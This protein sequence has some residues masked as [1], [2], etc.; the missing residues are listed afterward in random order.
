MRPDH[1]ALCSEPLQDDVAFGLGVELALARGAGDLAEAPEWVQVFPAGPAIEARDGRKWTL[2]DPQILVAALE[3]HGADLPLD[4]EHA[5][6]IRAPKGEEAPAQGWVQALQVRAD[7]TTW[8]RVDWNDAGRA[9]VVGRRYRYIS[10]AFRFTPDGQIVHLTSVA[11][12]TQPALR[13]PALARADGGDPSRK[14]TPSMSTL[15]ARLT[16][17]LGLAATATEDD[18]I[19]S[20]T[21]QVALARATND[22]SRF[23]PAADLTAALARASTAETALAARETADAEAQATARVAAAIAAGKLAPASEEHWQA[24][25]RSS[26]DAFDK[27]VAAMPSI[28]APTKTDKKVDGDQVGEHGLTAEQL[29]VCRSLGTDPVAF[30]ATLKEEGA[31]Q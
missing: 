6:E 20:V 9:A 5:S 24:I 16:A 4:I 18:V 15:L 23:V 31:A 10:P 3:G 14:E 29:A 28:L 1:L 30:A 27:A 13:M 19:A 12:T 25:A 21:G 7:G 26:P 2:A 8:A 22:P 11:L 17:A